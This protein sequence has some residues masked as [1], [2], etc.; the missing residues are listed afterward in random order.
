MKQA[1]P[2]TDTSKQVT[3]SARIMLFS[4]SIL[5]VL[6][7]LLL[8]LPSATI[9]YQPQTRIQNLSL[10]VHA[11]P[12][13]SAVSLAGVIPAHPLALVLHSIKT[14]PVQNEM[15]I[16]DAFAT[17]SVQFT[18]MT[19][20]QVSIPANTVIRS[21]EAPFT[22]FAT[23]E[24]AVLVPGLEKTVDVHVRAL[25][26]GLKGNLAAGSLTS[27]EGDLGFSVSVTNPQAMSGGSEKTA[28]FP[29]F[30]E[31]SLLRETM[32]ASL[33]DECQISLGGKHH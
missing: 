17:G 30:D 12:N 18:N 21:I 32:M 31:R 2:G 13:V 33:Q 8:F 26:P 9:D 23:T 1:L 5:A 6:V 24:D 10:A 7:V 4:L 14:L 16:P 29:S 11:D 19:E 20:F 27:V 28:L 25:E 15:L 22:R 3:P